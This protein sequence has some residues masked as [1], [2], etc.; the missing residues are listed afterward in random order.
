VPTLRVLLVLLAATLAAPVAGAFASPP[1]ND[2]PDGATPFQPVTAGNGHPHD[3]QGIA[4]LAEAT[5]DPGVPRCLGPGSFERTV[6]FRAAAT[7]TPQRLTVE[8]SGPTLAVADIAAFVQPHGVLAPLRRQPNACSGK[9]AGGADAAEEPTSGLTI[10]VPAGRDVLFQVGARGAAGSPDSERLVVSLDSQPQQAGH[11]PAGDLAGG[12]TPTTSSKHA[13]FV[14]LAHATIT[15]DDPADPVC[16][17]AGSVWRRFKPTHSGPL[18]ISAAASRAGALSVYSGKAPTQANELDCVNRSSVGALE[19][20]VPAH[21]GRTLWLRIGTEDAQP[22]AREK[23]RIDD[24]HGQVVIH[25]GPGGFDP[26]AGGPGGGLPASCSQ[27]HPERAR[28]VGPRIGGTTAAVNGR[29]ALSLQ[30]S[31]RGATICDVQADLVGPRGR[32]YATAV[33]RRLSGRTGLSLRRTLHLGRG[34][35]RLRITAVGYLGNR[36][37]VRSTVR[38]RL[39]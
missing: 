7:P 9:G 38:G 39:R 14:S 11:A 13:T 35:Y 25:G 4:E 1:P 36:V 22:G 2:G 27:S 32:V 21:K 37:T 34:A 17:A 29:G 23:L 33:A 12:T 20:N 31:V 30:F 28:I 19:M 15:E 24:G 3:L 18:L 6:W 26:T 8:A 5:P 16:P 10:D